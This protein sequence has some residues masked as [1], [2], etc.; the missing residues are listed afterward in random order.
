[1]S[2]HG[3]RGFVLLTGAALVCL[4]QCS[5]GVLSELVPARRTRT[6][7]TVTAPVGGAVTISLVLV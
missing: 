1:M 3:P 7:L 4:G 6:T 5:Q 2:L